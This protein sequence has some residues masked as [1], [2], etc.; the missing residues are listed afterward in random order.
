MELAM[1]LLNMWSADEK[2]KK[3]YQARLDS[4]KAKK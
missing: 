1:G 4:L 3:A 2:I